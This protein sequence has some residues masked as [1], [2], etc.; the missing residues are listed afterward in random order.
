MEVLLGSLGSLL[1]GVADFLGGEGAK[2]VSAA[3]VVVWSGVFSFPL[4]LIAAILVGGDAGVADYMLGLAA[5]VSGALGLN[6]LFA[7]LARGRAAVVAP[8][9]A[10]MGAMI[11]V[12]AAVL[13]GDRPSTLAW[14]GVAVAIP[15]I[16]LSAWTDDDAG[17]IRI[18][19]VYGAAAGLG[20]GGFTAIIGFTSDQSNLLPLIAS[21]GATVVAVLLVVRVGWWRLQPLSKAPRSIIVGNG[22]LDVSAN[23]V[24]LIALRVGEFALA[25][26]AASFYPAV[27]VIMAKVVNSEHLRSRQ[28][29]GI[30]LTLVAL[31]L[32]G[33]G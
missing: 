33:L 18:G 23:V 15:A 26:V 29:V 3:T 32:I 27:T 4:L 8:A 5:G 20:F 7:G 14:I 17:P 1:W 2:R 24:V 11:P 31:A 10:A 19:L 22:V 28:V 30:S 9:S 16:A 12:S 13:A 6:M 25:A 21:R